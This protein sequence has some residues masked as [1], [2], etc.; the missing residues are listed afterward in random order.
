MANVFRYKYILGAIILLPVLIYS[1]LINGFFQQDEWWVFGNAFFNKELSVT[2]KIINIF[3][4]KVGH[5]TPLRDLLFEILFPIYRLNYNFWFYTSILGHIICSLLVFKLTTQITKNIKI[6]TIAAIIFAVAASGSQATSW[7]VTSLNTH[8]A[9]IFYLIS[10]ILFF[11]FLD[12][13]KVNVLIKSLIFLCISLLFKEIAL[14]SFALFVILI[15][16]FLKSDKQ[17]KVKSIYIII[18]FAA[19]Y[20]SVR[21]SA[22]LMSTPQV[23][24]NNLVTQTQS[25]NFLIY[26]LVTFPSKVFVQTLIPPK[27]LLSI[28][29]NIGY[30]LPVSLTNQKGTTE[31]DLF[32]EKFLLQGVI[33][34]IFT[35]LSILVFK[36]IYK[37]RNLR[38][39]NTIIFSYL[40]ILLNSFVYALSP[41][42]SGIITTIDSRNLYLPMVGM[43]ILVPITIFHFFKSRFKQFIFISAVIFINIF[44]L[45]SDLEN[46]VEEGLIRKNIL[47]KISEVGNPLPQK[48]IFYIQSDKSYYGLPE[49][50]L[51]IPF[52]SG[53]GQTLLVWNSKD[54]NLP[55]EFYQDDFLWDI[56]S[57]GYKEVNNFAFG[58]FRN[59]K[60]LVSEIEKYKLQE[61][62]IIAFRYD[63]KNDNL[64]NITDSIKAQVIGYYSKK[65]LSNKFLI[66]SSNNS[67]DLIKLKDDKIETFW[68]SQIPYINPQYLEIDFQKFVNI[69]QIQIDSYNNQDQNKVGYRILVSRDKKDWREVYFNSFIPPEKNGAVDIYMNESNIRFMKIEQIGNHAF[70]SWVIHE[71]KIYEKVN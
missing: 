13:K 60:R 10:L 38:I 31:Y 29:K 50:E 15:P 8:G 1:I 26:N 3:I 58:Y 40:F 9:L 39:R 32:I 33:F 34:L 16:L 70:A 44:W 62:T 18:L 4:P 53:F 21:M 25:V 14:L 6:A 47:G 35:I 19:I 57:Q 68:D 46:L 17:K 43:S 61:N 54:K 5:Y 37:N 52:Q 42:T 64:I 67:V 63:S 66:N 51:I 2:Q 22:L 65:K 20:I 55:K 12:N 30:I 23:S 56:N 27:E 69:A 49:N 71:L 7:I 36:I 24:D 41:N 45:R 11:K 48:T 28:V 59:F